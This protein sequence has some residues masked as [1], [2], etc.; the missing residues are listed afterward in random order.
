MAYTTPAAAQTT[1]VHSTISLRSC[2]AACTTEATPAMITAMET[3]K[4][5]N[6]PRTSRS[7][8][9]RWCSSCCCWIEAI[10]SRI[11]NVSDVCS[12]SDS[13]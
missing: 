2:A 11:S 5:K 3:S 1:S 7:T 4:A 12:I 9:V 6:T 13:S 10:R 8:W